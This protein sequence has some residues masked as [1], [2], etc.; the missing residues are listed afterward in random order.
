M[1]LGLVQETGALTVEVANDSLDWSRW[2]ASLS[3][4]EIF[5]LVRGNDHRR[6]QFLLVLSSGAT[7]S[8]TAEII[9]SLYESSFFGDGLSD[10]GGVP[11]PHIGVLTV[12]GLLL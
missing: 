9:L 5:I 6:I 2:S 7:I 3:I 1:N 10:L 11:D 4:G 12:Q 8:E